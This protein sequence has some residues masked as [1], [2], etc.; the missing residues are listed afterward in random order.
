MNYKKERMNQIYSTAL[1][2]KKADARIGE[3]WCANGC[4]CAACIIVRKEI[5]RLQI[6]K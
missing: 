2:H 1:R 6:T 5:E 4:Q 3:D